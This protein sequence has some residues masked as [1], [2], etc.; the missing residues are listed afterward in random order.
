MLHTSLPHT[1]RIY[2]LRVCDPAQA[3][4]GDSGDAVGDA[5]AVAE[6]LRAVVQE[7]D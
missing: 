1:F 6:F 2:T 3:A 4:G 5:V 7:A